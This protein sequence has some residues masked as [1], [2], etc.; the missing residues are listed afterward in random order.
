[1]CGPDISN[2]KYEKYDRLDSMHY[3]REHDRIG[4]I[5]GSL[6]RAYYATRDALFTA[7]TAKAEVED[8][9]TPAHREELAH[10]EA[11]A[12]LQAKRFIKLARQAEIILP[13]GWA[14]LF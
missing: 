3:G 8:L 14:E 13:D 2:T 6:E 5:G 10:S 12:D 7:K 4:N 9:A 11:V 1:M